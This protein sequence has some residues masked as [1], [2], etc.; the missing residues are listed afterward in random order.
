MLEYDRIDTSEGIDINKTSLSK[1]CDICHYSYLKNIGFKHESCLCNGCH[2]LMKKL[3]VL[4]I[5]L[6]FMLKE[7]HPEFIFGI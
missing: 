3:W 5:L 4:T 6:L 7:M 2:D 1:Q